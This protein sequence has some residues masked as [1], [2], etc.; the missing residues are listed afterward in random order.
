MA[1][2]TVQTASR[3]GIDVSGVTPT[4]STGDTFANTGSE[5]LLVRNGSGAPI[6]VTFDIT[7]TLDAQTVTD[8]AVTVG[9]GV[10]K[11]IGP[12]PTG[13]YNDGNASVKATCSAV[14][15]VTV[16][17]VKLAKG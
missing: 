14:T 11:L 16:A 6:T 5:F 12:F 1:A 4:A 15:T 13:W 3:D 7:A 17:A 2:L 10:K 8:R 9:A